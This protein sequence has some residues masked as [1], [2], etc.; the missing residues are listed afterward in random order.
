MCDRSMDAREATCAR[1]QEASGATFIHPYDFAP[2]ICGQGTLALELLEQVR[3]PT[4]LDTFRIFIHF[5]ALL[6]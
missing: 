5:A 6:L 2:T 3:R 1:L 4:I